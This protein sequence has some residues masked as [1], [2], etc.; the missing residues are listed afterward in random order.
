[1]DDNETRFV[2]FSFGR[3]DRL[4]YWA[5]S[6][7]CGLATTEMALVLSVAIMSCLIGQASVHGEGQSGMTR[8]TVQ[9]PIERAWNSIA[10]LHEVRIIQ[11][12]EQ[13]DE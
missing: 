3:V 9:T 10:E 11:A 4:S 5:T 8:Q 13:S 12:M 1:M 6:I 2:N 7:W